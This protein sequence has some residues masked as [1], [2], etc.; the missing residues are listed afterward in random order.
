MYK[1]WTVPQ[2]SIMI[3]YNCSWSV[4]IQQIRIMLSADNL[5]QKIQKKAYFLFVINLITRSKKICRLGRSLKICGTIHSF[6][7]QVTFLTI[8]GTNI[9]IFQ[10]YKWLKQL[11]ILN[12]LKLTYKSYIS[13]ILSYK[14]IIKCTPSRW[15]NRDIGFC[16]S[17]QIVL[18]YRTVASKCKQESR[19]QHLSRPIC[20][21]K[22]LFSLIKFC[23]GLKRNKKT[24]IVVLYLM[25]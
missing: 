2:L 1:Q 22:C 16:L 14:A 21:A 7:I 11:K 9:H 19:D 8:S 12:V 24:I 20:V 18:L 13:G 23:F 15:G 17:F 10:Q 3:I 6:Y 25:F 5:T 4:L